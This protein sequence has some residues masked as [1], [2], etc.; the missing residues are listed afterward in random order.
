MDISELPHKGTSESGLKTADNEQA[1]L[2]KE[3]H[4]ELALDS[5]VAQKNAGSIFSKNF[6]YEPLLGVHP[7]HSLEF[8]H[9]NF[10]NSFVGKRMKWPI[11]ISSMTG[12][13]RSAGLINKRLAK[14]ANRFGLAMGLGS[15]RAL[16]ESKERLSDFDVRA[17]LGEESPLFANIG[18][19]QLESLVENKELDRLEELVEILRCD[20]IIV[21]IN[22][23]QEWFQ[24]EGDRLQKPAIETLK[25][26]IK[27]FK[28]SVIVKEVGQGFGP[29]S[30][31]E[32]LKLP[33]TAIDLSGFGG[34]NFSKLESLRLEEKCS[35]SFQ[36]GLIGQGHSNVEMLQF[37]E[38]IF[39]DDQN[40]FKQVRERKTKLIFSGGIKDFLE[41]IGFIEAS[42]ISALYAQAKDFLVHAMNSQEELDEYVQSQI[43]GIQLVQQFFKTKGGD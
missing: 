43:E 33:L 27:N 38:D 11:M 25:S 17:D 15:C 34:T 30:L 3:G 40:L 1:A 9:Q 10:E 39:N 26:F 19:N 5:Q 14:T 20:G 35:R 13:S 8:S 32:L 28:Y 23:L 21:H 7:S 31:K 2:R 22:P 16:L 12:G 29:Q 18:I 37:I 42:P 24:P 6:H 41:G 4:I 36:Q